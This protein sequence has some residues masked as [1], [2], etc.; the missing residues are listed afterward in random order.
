MNTHEAKKV[1]ARGHEL[2]PGHAAAKFI[3]SCLCKDV[4]WELVLGDLLTFLAVCGI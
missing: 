1:L 2:A 4:L 3:Y